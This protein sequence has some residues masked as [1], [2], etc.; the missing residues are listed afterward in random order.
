ME[1]RKYLGRAY[2]DYYKSFASRVI[3][4]DEGGL[5]GYAAR[6]EIREVNRPLLVG[7]PDAQVCLADDGYCELQYLPDG[8]H[9]MVCAIRDD[10]GGMVEWYFDITR[11]NA[12]D[13][14]GAP[15]CDDLYLD[16]ALLPDERV[17]IFDEDELRVALDG[18]G[19]TKDEYD[20]AHRTL[21]GLLDRG[22]ISLEYQEALYARL[23]ALF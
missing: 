12:V 20:M 1:R 8:E 7:E 6:V 2:K 19:V 13:E 22:I 10:R 15:Y 14:A 9:W 17:L 21:R 18:G 16:A 4:V 23:S 11:K 5:R 3:R